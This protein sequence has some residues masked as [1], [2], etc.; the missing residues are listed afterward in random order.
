MPT[1]EDPADAL[2][3][4]FYMDTRAWCIY[5]PLT[6][7]GWGTGNPLQADGVCDTRKV[8]FVTSQPYTGNLGGVDGADAECATEAQNAGLTGT[9]KAWISD[10][11]H[12]PA[13]DFT[14]D[15][16]PYLLPDLS[17]KV[18]DDW[19]DLTDD[20]LDNPID[21]QA[22][23]VNTEGFSVWT[24]TAPNGTPTSTETPHSCDDWTYPTDGGG[25]TATIGLADSTDTDWT[26][27]ASFR[28]CAEQHHLYCV[29]Q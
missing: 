25:Q 11:T 5:G 24:T 29:Q 15:G 9:F 10:S 21:Q 7:D 8:V 6:E 26:E 19:A 17:T 13:Q 12:S 3:G 14:Q 1:D 2:P 16:G 4:D 22:D 23:G 20:S 18:A 27:L 28:S